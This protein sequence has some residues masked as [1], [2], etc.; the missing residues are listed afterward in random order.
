MEGILKVKCVADLV[1]CS[2]L[3]SVEETSFTVAQLTAPLLWVFLKYIFQRDP[4]VHDMVIVHLMQICACSPTGL[5]YPDPAE[6]EHHQGTW[7]P[8]VHSGVL[9][10]HAIQRLSQSH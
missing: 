5:G 9:T 3:L 1:S 6:S 8:S 4:T 10:Q 7:Q 2:F